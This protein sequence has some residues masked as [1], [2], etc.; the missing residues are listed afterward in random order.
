MFAI[1]APMGLSDTFTA[2]VVSALGR[3]TRVPAD[4]GTT[5]LISSAIQT[6]AS[7]NPGNSGGTLANCAGELV[8]VPT[9]GATA[10]DSSGGAVGGSIGLGFAIPADFAHRIADLL[11]ADGKVTHGVFGL[12]VV[13]VASG[14]GIQTD[15]LYVAS[16]V[17]G[18]AAA[19][20]GLAE[21]DI[22]TSLDGQAVT[23]ADQLQAISINKKPGDVVQVGYRRDGEERTVALTLG[24]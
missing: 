19:A 14:D 8:G 20:A 4:N 24:S 13:P 21:A 2:G 18:G 7:I 6:D 1:G 12:S 5:A 22:I 15:G 9:A 11:I 16:V 10:N 3:S 23:S 17:D